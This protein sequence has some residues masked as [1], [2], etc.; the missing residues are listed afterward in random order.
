MTARGDALLCTDGPVRTLV[1][2][3]L[4]PDANRCAARFFCLRFGR[5]EGKH[6]MVPG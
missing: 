5:G 6:Q 1:G 4:A 2:L 3:A